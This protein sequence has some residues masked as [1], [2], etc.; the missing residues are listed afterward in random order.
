MPDYEISIRRTPA[1]SDQH[2]KELIKLALREDIGAGDV[3]SKAIVAPELRGMGQIVAKQS[4]VLSGITV[5]RR[6]FEAIEDGIVWTQNRRDGE[7]CEVGEVI[8]IV[9]GKAQSL[10]KGERTALNFLQ[11]LS[12]IATATARFVEALRDTK[13]RILDTRKT[14]PGLREL[15]KQAVEAGGGTNHRMGLYDHYLIKNNHISIAGSISEAIERAQRTKQP[16]QLIEVEAR[17]LEEVE[18]AVKM[19]VDII[20]LDNMPVDRVKKAVKLVKGRAKLE[21]SGNI[22]LDNLHSYAATGVDF[23]SVGAITHSAPAADI[24]MPIATQ[25]TAEEISVSSLEEMSRS[26]D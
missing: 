24:N 10:L 11:H 22:T 18:V 4:L 1:L 21:A 19:A 3:T 23:I 2:L 5:A 26:Q 15:E 6:V 12:G 13:T 20:L 9:E 14:I 25:R 17:S 7:R 8:A 16:G